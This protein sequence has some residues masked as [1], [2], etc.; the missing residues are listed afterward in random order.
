MVKEIVN[1]DPDLYEIDRFF[2]LKQESKDVFLIFYNWLKT[3]GEITVTPKQM[4]LRIGFKGHT[5]SA[6]G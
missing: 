3:L 1:Q 2:N 5:F 4:L 6:I